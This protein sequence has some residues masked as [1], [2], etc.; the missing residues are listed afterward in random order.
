MTFHIL[1][2][3]TYICCPIL[4]DLGKELKNLITMMDQEEEAEN[5]ASA[6]SNRK[7]L[8]KN[9]SVSKVI[10]TNSNKESPV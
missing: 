3:F 4:G 10:T 8:P 2:I 9:M 6:S 7:P 1:Q 5:T